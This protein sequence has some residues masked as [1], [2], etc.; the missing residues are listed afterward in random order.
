MIFQ[1]PGLMVN[2][3]K[4]E[5]ADIPRMAQWLSSD[6]YIENF[7]GTRT[8]DF[9]FYE[10]Q[11]MDMLQ[12]NAD[13]FS[14]NKYFL[15]EDRFSGR[16]IGLAMLCKIDWKNRHA[17]YSYIVGEI[18]YRSKLVAG[19]VNMVL[20]NHFFNNLNLNKVY[21]F[22]VDAN[23]VSQRMNGFGGSHDGTLRMHRIGSSG[24]AT[25]VHVFSITKSSFSDFVNKHAHTL[26]AKHIARGLIK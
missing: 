8:A 10:K 3:R 21:G 5:I 26:L 19:D 1:L 9:S 16:P 6:G 23:A 13:D 4:P 22:V 17:E 7:C 20:Y 14:G 12:K 18:D 24:V 11:A 25:D 15:A 2:I